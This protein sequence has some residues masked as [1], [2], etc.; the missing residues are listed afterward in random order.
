MNPSNVKKIITPPPEVDVNV[1]QYEHLRQ[2]ILELNLLVTQLKGVCTAQ[3]CPKMKATEAW[4]Y[5]CAVHKKE[6]QDVPSQ[7]ELVL[8]NGL[9][10][11]Q[12]RPGGIIPHQHQKL[13]K[14]VKNFSNI[15]S[16]SHSKES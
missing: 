15:E 14:Q 9:Y 10:D 7:L 2:F 6:A 4:L 11:P 8:R 3:S 1:W 12:P 13:P 16:Q 5:L